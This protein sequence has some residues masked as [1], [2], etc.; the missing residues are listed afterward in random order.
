MLAKHCLVKR[1]RHWHVIQHH[2]FVNNH[3]L[4]EFVVVFTIDNADFCLFV[5]SAGLFISLEK[6]VKMLVDYFE[7]RFVCCLCCHNNKKQLFAHRKTVRQ[8]DEFCQD[9]QSPTLGLFVRSANGQHSIGA[10]RE[11]WVVRATATSPTQLAMFEF[12]GRLIG[13][14]LR[15]DNHLNVDFSPLLWKFL[16][17]E[18]PSGD[19]LHNVDA[20][21]MQSLAALRT[22]DQQGVTAESFEDVFMETFTTNASDGGEV[23]LVPDGRRRKVTAANRL[24]FADLVRI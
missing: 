21:C 12:L 11:I 5:C 4:G 10:E 22:I 6:V 16:V 7:S 24:L 3:V 1:L 20:M 19:D 2:C 23:E 13:V 15:T 8:L 18:R 17:G 14:A 9:L